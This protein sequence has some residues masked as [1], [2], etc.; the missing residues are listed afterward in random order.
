MFLPRGD[1]A[2]PWSCHVLAMFLPCSYHVFAML[3][4]L[5]EPSSC[6]EWA[7]TCNFYPVARRT[8]QSPA[9]QQ[10]QQITDQTTTSS[11]TS[12]R[13]QTHQQH[14]HTHTHTHTLTTTCTHTHTRARS[15]HERVNNIAAVSWQYRHIHGNNMARPWQ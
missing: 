4:A 10:G 11:H 14:T 8:M 3:H 9:M 6:H 7:P 12:R 2:L 1:M 13:P 15:W 5:A